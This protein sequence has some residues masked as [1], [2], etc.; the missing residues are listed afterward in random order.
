MLRMYTLYILECDIQTC[1]FIRNSTIVYASP[2]HPPP[3]Q[4]RLFDFNIILTALHYHSLRS[5]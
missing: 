2:T 5:L 1:T 4:L 3:P